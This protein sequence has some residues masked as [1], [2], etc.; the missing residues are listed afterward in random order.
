MGIR[1]EQHNGPSHMES[2][3]GVGDHNRLAREGEAV[4]NSWPKIAA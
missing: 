4:A 3:D 1:E 2:L